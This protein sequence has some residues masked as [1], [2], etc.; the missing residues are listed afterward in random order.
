MNAGP[1]P[2]ARPKRQ[3][4]EHERRRPNRWTRWLGGVLGL[5]VLLLLGWAARKVDWLAVLAAVKALP[6]GVLAAAAGLAVLSHLIYSTFDL[7]GRAWTGHGAPVRRVMMITF[8]CYAFNLNL[9]ALVGGFA[10]R[11]RL[12]SRL[13]LDTP[14]IAR[15]IALSLTT[16][17]LGYG[18]LAGVMFL[19]RQIAPPADW[20]LSATALQALGGLMCLLVAGYLG[21]CAW[22]RWRSFSVRGHEISLPQLRM[23]LLQLLLSSANWM[24]MG[25]VVFL[26]LQRAVPYPEVLAVLLV[27]AVAGV[28]THVPAG[29]GVLEAVFL[30]LLAPPLAGPALLAA[31]LA[32]RALYYLLPLMGAAVLY[33]TLEARAAR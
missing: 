22:S 5:A 8:V 14:V 20:T 7:I 33:F 13:G 27:A 32:Y 4:E 18:L 29:I 11:F 16:N 21:L 12:Y 17:W 19:T 30:A 6:P 15:V 3:Q 26:L 31:L 24:V 1:A 25:G 2:A 28:V 9:G 23:A 10:L